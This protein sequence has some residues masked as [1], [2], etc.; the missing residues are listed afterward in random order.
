[1]LDHYDQLDIGGEEYRGGMRNA[2]CEEIGRAEGETA[3]QV[4]EH[5]DLHL[6]TPAWKRRPVGLGRNLVNDLRVDEPT[7]LV[8][9]LPG[10]EVRRAEVENDTLTPIEEGAVLDHYTHTARRQAERALYWTEGS[11][12]HERPTISHIRCNAD[13]VSEEHFRR[14]QTDAG[15]FVAAKESLFDWLTSYDCLRKVEHGYTA[16]I[17]P[18]TAPGPDDV[19]PAMVHLAMAAVA[20][21]HLRPK[22]MKPNPIMAKE[23]LKVLRQMT[24]QIRAPNLDGVGGQVGGKRQIQC[25]QKHKSSK[26]KRLNWKQ[27]A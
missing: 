18:E 25:L 10:I 4:V 12:H 20:T 1:M 17:P 24:K 22:E 13:N 9:D 15:L 14:M 7:N 6:W 8:L 19:I 2:F 11:T 23:R 26:F 27:S 21:E 3:V 16:G 5:Q